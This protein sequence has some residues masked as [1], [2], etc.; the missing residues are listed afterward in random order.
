MGRDLAL[1]AL[2]TVLAGT[3]VAAFS[4]LAEMLKPKMFAGLFAGAPVVAG[5]SLVLTGLNKPN[6]AVQGST[7]MIA[8]ACGMVAC[9]LVAALVLPK[10]GALVGSGLAWITWAVVASALYVLFLA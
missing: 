2:K 9:C 8:G 3:F 6:A 10:V 4:L 7:G 5:V 1:L